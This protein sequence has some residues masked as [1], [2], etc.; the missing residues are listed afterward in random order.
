MEKY[1]LK[2]GICDDNS[3]VC[4]EIEKSVLQYAGEKGIIRR[5]VHNYCFWILSLAIPPELRLETV[6][7][8]RCGII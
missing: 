6:S 4:S 7:G 2:I 1:K 8:N 3:Y 5:M